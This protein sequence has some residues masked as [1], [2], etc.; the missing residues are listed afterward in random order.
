[1]AT[2]QLT[3]LSQTLQ[4]SM[5][6]SVF[7]PAEVNGGR[8]NGVITLLHGHSNNDREWMMYSSA[9]RYASDNGY[10]LICP[11]ADNSFYHDHVY[12]GAYYTWLTQ[13]LPEQLDR[14]FHLP[15]EREKNFIAG[16]SM[17]GYGA[18]RVALNHPERYAA[19]GSFSGAL[20]INLLLLAGKLPFLPRETRK[21]AQETFRPVFG[22]MLRLPKNANI[23]ALT[24]RHAALPK[25]QQLR[26]YCSCGKQDDTME[27]LAQNRKYQKFA[28]TLP[29]DYTYREWDGVHEWSFWDTCLA[30]FIGFI[31][32][33]GYG[34][35]QRQNWAEPL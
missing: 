34:A 1:M 31:Q 24:K 25:E 4:R 16:L 23:F 12:G 26:I 21:F 3:L 30:E 7:Y 11:S 29:L 18:L 33:S 14:L 13:E 9:C 32:N 5:H 15:A 8:V 10:V 17:G 6:V 20:D 28:A 2:I 35:D 22:R 27:I 19:C